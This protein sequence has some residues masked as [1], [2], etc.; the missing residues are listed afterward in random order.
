[1]ISNFKINFIICQI[2]QLLRS[3]STSSLTKSTSVVD[4]TSIL[5]NL[6]KS[7][8]NCRFADENLTLARILLIHVC[9]R[10]LFVLSSCCTIRSITTWTTFTVGRIGMR[11]M[12]KLIL[13]IQLKRL[14][15]LIQGKS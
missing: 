14:S 12:I 10:R 13:T 2:W 7:S 4:V 1:M 8:M 11:I 15:I 3:K 5:L 9:L 6:T